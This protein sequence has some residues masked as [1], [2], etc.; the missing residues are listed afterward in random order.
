MVTITQE[1]FSA[2]AGETE[3]DLLAQLGIAVAG[4]ELAPQGGLGSL[5]N[6]KSMAWPDWRALGE[7]F[8][9][10]VWPQIKGVLCQAYEAYTADN[11]DWIEQAAT[12][13]LALMNVG[14]AIAVL[15]VKIALKKGL[16]S[17]C[18]LNGD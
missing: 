3:D 4:T 11:K 18:G 2:F 17:L 8:F 15:L 1:D 13:L 5:K 9:S 12:A 7:V 16:D 6:A 14:S 10:R